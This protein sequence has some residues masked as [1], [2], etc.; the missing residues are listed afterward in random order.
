MYTTNI[1][2]SLDSALHRLNCQ[3]SVFPSDTSLLKAVYLVTFEA[4][5]NGLSTYLPMNLCGKEY[6]L[7]P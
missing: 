5:K 6:F 1:I 4:T 3:R 2:E 7:S